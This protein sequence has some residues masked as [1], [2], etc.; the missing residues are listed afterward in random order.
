[1]KK[2]FTLIEVLIY[3]SLSSLLLTGVIVST[4]SLIDGNKWLFKNTL[5]LEEG[6]FALQKIHRFLGEENIEIFLDDGRLWIV[7]NKDVAQAITSSRVFVSNFDLDGEHFQF[8]INGMK[9]KK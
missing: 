1:M 8:V 3:I 2:G 7:R 4:F 9:F 5:A 6:H